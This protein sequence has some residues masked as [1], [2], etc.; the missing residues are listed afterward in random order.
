M[1]TYY[2]I[3]DII[4]YHTRLWVGGTVSKHFTFP[5]ITLYFTVGVVHVFSFSQSS[6]DL[7]LA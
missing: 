1:L 2:K 7:R 5:A 3:V 6:T 4:F